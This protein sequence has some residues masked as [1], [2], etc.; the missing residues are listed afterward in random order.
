M[1]E[2]ACRNYFK[3]QCNEINILKKKQKPDPELNHVHL[4]K[5]L[6]SLCLSFLKYKMRIKC[7]YL[8]LGVGVKQLDVIY[9]GS[10]G[11]LILMV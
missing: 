10:R 4:V 8:G 9:R 2:L 1:K 7:L 6:T 11:S 3:T 5:L